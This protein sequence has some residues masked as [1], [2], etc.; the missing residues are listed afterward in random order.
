MKIV[1]RHS[2]LVVGCFAVTLGSAAFV[3]AQTAADR[4]DA[5]GVSVPEVSVSQVRIV[6]LSDVQGAVQLD[7]QAGHGFERAFLNLPILQGEDLK[8]DQGWAEVEF[9]DNGS[10]RLTPGSELSFETLGRTAAGRVLN[11]VSLTRGTLYVSL[12]DDKANDFVVHADGATITLPP[13]SHIRL[14]VYPTGSE[15]YVVKGKVQV[16]EGADTMILGRDHALSFGGASHAALAPI[17]EKTP[18]LYDVKDAEAV[19]YH[20]F[21]HGGQT[22][23][24]YGSQDLQTYGSFVDLGGCGLVWQPYLASAAWSPYG[25]GYWSWYPSAGYSWVSPYPWGWTPY[26]SGQWMQCG[27][28][29]SWGWKPGQSFVGLKNAT[30]APISLRKPVPPRTPRPGESTLIVAGTTPLAR[31]QMI[32]GKYFVFA[33]DSAGLGLPRSAPLNLANISNQVRAHG[34]SMVELPSGNVAQ[35]S[36][37]LEALRTAGDIGFSHAGDPAPALTSRPVSTREAGEA[38]GGYGGAGILSAPAGLGLTEPSGWSAQ[39]RA[40][41]GQTPSAP[42]SLSMGRGSA[43][44][45]VPSGGGNSSGGSHH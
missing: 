11:A 38:R 24:A 15:L 16:A 8:T 7:K 2:A 17:R 9:E 18:G 20:Q 29:Q 45:A 30:L 4:G 14:D 44:T 32:E 40:G 3:G 12:A 28:N 27:A 23:Y 19:K 22:P 31:S 39:N 34:S 6:R 25:N 41:L 42:A 37:T 1:C 5:S 21:Q 33:S 43:I 35:G 26:H 10:L 13:A 36:T